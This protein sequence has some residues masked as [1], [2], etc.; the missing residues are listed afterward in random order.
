MARR[1]RTLIFALAI[2]L[3]LAFAILSYPNFQKW[4]GHVDVVFRSADI[5]NL[6]SQLKQY[7]V[8]TITEIKYRVDEGMFVEIEI[9]PQIRETPG[10]YVVRMWYVD[11]QEMRSRILGSQPV[12]GTEPIPDFEGS[13]PGHRLRGFYEAVWR[14]GLIQGNL[15]RLYVGDCWFY[16]DRG[17]AEGWLLSLGRGKHLRACVRYDAKSEWEA[18][19][20]TAVRDLISTLQS[21]ASE[22]AKPAHPDS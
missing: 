14:S 1:K 2:G 12:D 11:A 22:R 6:S 18:T 16:S 9:G 21:L 4:N 10:F 3:I 17:L 8:L 7:G 15:G 19:L 13:V 5:P 20:N